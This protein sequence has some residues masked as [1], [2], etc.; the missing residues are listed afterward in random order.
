M[1]SDDAPTPGRERYVVTAS[2]RS[3]PHTQI[4]LYA[5]LEHDRGKLAQEHGHP[6][7]ADI[8]MDETE[9]KYFVR[10][11]GERD[12]EFVSTNIVSASGFSGEYFHKF[13]AK[14]VSEK[15]SLTHPRYQGRTPEHIRAEWENSART[16]T[17][18]HL[19]LEN[20]FNGVPLPSEHFA[21][22][23]LQQFRKWRGRCLVQSGHTPWRTEMKLYSSREYLLVG[24][25]DLVCVDERELQ[26]RLAQQPDPAQVRLPLVLY[27]HKFSKKIHLKAFADKTGFGPCQR[28]PCTNFHKYSLAMHLYRWMLETYY[29]GVRYRGRV[30]RNAEILAMYLDVFHHTHEDYE[31]YKIPL[32]GP[33]FEV[34]KEMLRLR[35]TAVARLTS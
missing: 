21:D 15:L 5:S 28:V 17:A 24:T 2:T 35:K 19:M 32:E 6:R 9:H 4:H 26:R 10:F 18:Y 7:D 12:T 33:V 16:G 29:T 14:A 23:P 20:F 13:D 25:L 22:K 30:F 31:M 8:Y 3:I 1:T 11:G 34:F 27:D